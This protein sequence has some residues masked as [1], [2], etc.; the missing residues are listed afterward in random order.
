MS[1]VQP[2]MYTFEEITLL[3]AWF[4]GR[5]RMLA[6]QEMALLDRLGYEV[7]PGD[8]Y[9]RLD[10]W[11]GSFATRDVQARLPNWALVYADGQVVTSR[12]IDPDR[13]SV[14][15]ACL[16]QFLLEINWAD[17]G[18]G[19][20][21]PAEYRL[22]WLPGFD[23]HIVS[24]SADTAEMLGYC[25]F[26]LGSFSGCVSAS[27]RSARARRIIV[28]DWRTQFELYDQWP[29]EYLFRAGAVSEEEAMQWRAE[30]WAG[31]ELCALAKEEGE[32]GE[33]GGGSVV[34]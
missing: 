18:P 25:D 11:V 6:P 14:T 28:A 23:R 20:S 15:V 27:E 24:Y 1:A 2:A 29:W 30:A 17:S 7:E 3:E 34:E 4:E 32:E 26:A 9:T 19:Y 5:G 22:A 13:R 31:H 21:W 16:S 33:E 8:L 10:A 12:K